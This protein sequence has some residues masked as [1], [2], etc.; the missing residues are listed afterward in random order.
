MDNAPS[1]KC[2]CEVTLSPQTT[3]P[4]LIFFEDVN[5]RLNVSCTT[6]VG[7]EVARMWGEQTLYIKD[8]DWMF[9]LQL[10]STHLS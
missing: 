5:A 9:L 3:N 2:G 7:P 10:A 1:W 4:S 8:S 6:G